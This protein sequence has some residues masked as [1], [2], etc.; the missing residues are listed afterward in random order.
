MTTRTLARPLF[1]FTARE[2]LPAIMREGLRLGD[3]PTLTLRG[4]G[5]NAVWLTTNPSPNGHG[6]GSARELTDEDREFHRQLTGVLPPRGSRYPDKRAV[7]ITIGELPEP[8]RLVRWCRW[9]RRNVA[10][11]IY[12]CLARAG[13]EKHRSWYIYRGVIPPASFA[14]VEF[15]NGDGQYAPNEPVLA[16]HPADA[17]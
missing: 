11:E 4:P 14:A 6:L 5:Q 2:H 9:S 17:A 1:H 15:R 12:D 10:D 7:R 3:V 13:G 16:Q 8:A